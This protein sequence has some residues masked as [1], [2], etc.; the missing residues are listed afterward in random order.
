MSA[1]I[2]DGEALLGT[3]F[4][5]RIDT[6]WETQNRTLW[7]EQESAFE[8]RELVYEIS[9]IPELDS[10]RRFLRCQRRRGGTQ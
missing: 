9:W 2:I 10:W 1:S 7:N 4:P 6:Y 8:E 5:D 3:P